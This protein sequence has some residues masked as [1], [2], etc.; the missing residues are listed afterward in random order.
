VNSTLSSGLPE[1]VLD[2]EELTR[3][4]TSSRQFSKEH[5]AVKQAALLPNRNGV[6]S[7]FCHGMQPLSSLWDLADQNIHDRNVH[8]AAIFTAK[9][10]R[11]AELEV[12]AKEPPLR[13]ANIVNWPTDSDLEKAKRKAAALIITR[14]AELIVR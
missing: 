11:K 12:I 4:I 1:T 5:M 6:T 14:K 7:V 13:H 3:F 8:G 10:V 9:S 2:G